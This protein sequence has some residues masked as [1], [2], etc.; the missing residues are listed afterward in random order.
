MPHNNIGREISTIRMTVNIGEFDE[1]IL[2]NRYIFIS[3]SDAVTDIR[4]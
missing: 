4:G 3:T 2:I 1:I